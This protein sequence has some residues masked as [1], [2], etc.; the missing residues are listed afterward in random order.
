MKTPHQNFP[1]KTYAI[2][3]QTTTSQCRSMLDA[4]MACSIRSQVSKEPDMYSV[5][6][7]YKSPLSYGR[8]SPQYIRRK[9]LL[10]PKSCVMLRTSFM[11]RNVIIDPCALLRSPL[12]RRYCPCCCACRAACAW[13]KLAPYAWV[14]GCCCCWT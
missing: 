5:E 10:Y 12:Y 11:F 2:H 7:M 4:A 6:N 9:L 14:G 8:K 3:L 1:C 13:S